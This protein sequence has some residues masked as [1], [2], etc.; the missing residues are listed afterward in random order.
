MRRTSSVAALVAALLVPAAP[1]AAAELPDDARQ[2]IV[3]TAADT[4]T[5]HA[6]LTAYERSSDGRWTPVLTTDRVRLGSNGLVPAGERRQRSGTTPAGVFDIEWSFGRAADPG[7]RMRYVRIDRNDAWTYNPKVPATYNLF[8]SAAHDWSSYGPYVERL[9]RYGSQYDYVAVLDFNLP[10]GDVTVDA[11]GVRRTSRPANTTRGGGIFLHV[12]NGRSTA[13]CVAVP[14]ASMRRLLTW[15]DP[16][17]H[18][19]IAIGTT[20]MGRQLM[21]MSSSTGNCSR[22][23]AGSCGSTSA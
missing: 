18:P 21:T 20:A 9:W 10:D 19:V 7:T 17:K 16:A 22:H 4:H 1:A 8:Q 15:L 5:S 23:L 14:R 12:S 13:G 2:A 6:A 11:D 3:V